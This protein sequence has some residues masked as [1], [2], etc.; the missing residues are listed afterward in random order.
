[1]VTNNDKGQ[2]EQETQ[3]FFFMFRENTAVE[4]VR[5]YK[6]VICSV[7]PPPKSPNLKSL[8]ELVTSIQI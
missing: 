8:I 6:G 5:S 1:M 3:T 2:A 4:P 7:L